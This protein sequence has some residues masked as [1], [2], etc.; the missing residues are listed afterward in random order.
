MKAGEN[1][2][3]HTLLLM[4]LAVFLF[5]SP[6]FAWWAD[7]HPPWYSIFITWG[8]LIALIAINQ[9]RNSRGD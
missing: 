9:R 8:G 1:K 6:F 2:S 5:N 3:D 7:L 4:L